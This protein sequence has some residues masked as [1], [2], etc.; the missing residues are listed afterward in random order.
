MQVESYSSTKGLSIVGYYHANELVN[1]TN[2]SDTAQAIAS[3]IAQYCD[4]ACLLLV[5]RTP[6]CCAWVT[7]LVA[8]RV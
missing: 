1:D 8:A 3:K 4:K 2:I 7:P 6:W 5:S